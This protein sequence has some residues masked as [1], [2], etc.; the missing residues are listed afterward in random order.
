VTASESARSSRGFDLRQPALL[1]V[2]VLTL[3]YLSVL[4]HVTNVVGGSTTLLLVVAATVVL[5]TVLGRF[6]RVRSAI[7]LTALILVGGLAAYFFSVPASNRALFTVERVTSDTIAL[8]TG[9]SVLRLTKAGTWALAIAPGPVFLSWYLALRREYVWSVVVGGSALLF[10]VL[11]GDAGAATTLFGVV[12]AAAAIG[13]DTL[14]VRGGWASQLDTLAVVLAAMIV[15]SATLSV[16]PGGAAQPLLQDRGATTV[17]SSLVASN[18]QVN[19]LGSIR[20]SPKVRFEVRSDSAAYWQTAAYDRYTGSGWVRSGEDEAYS[21]RVD[22]PPGAS[23]TV[24]QNVE[25]KTRMTALP[26]AWKPVSVSGISEST[27]RITHQGNIVTTESVRTNESFRVRSELPRYTREQLRRSGSDYPSRISENYLQLPETTSDRVRGQA[28]E[29]AGNE[30]NAYDKAKAIEQYLESSKEYSLTVQKP[31]GDIAESFL[32]EMDAGY[33]TYYATSMVVMLRS[34]GIPARFVSGYTTGQQVADDKYVVRGLDS[35]AWVQVY[36]P[37]VGWVDFDPT[38]SGPRQTAEGAR[39]EEARQNQEEGVDTEETDPESATEN[40]SNTTETPTTPE[41]ETPTDNE[42]NQ[43]A[44][45]RSTVDPNRILDDEERL[46]QDGSSGTSTTGVTTTPDSSSGLPSLPSRETL[47]VG[48]ALMVGLAAGARRTGATERATRFVWMYYQ[49]ARED[50]TTDTERAFGRL[51]YCLERRYRARRPR[52]TP[53]SY[54]SALS[55]VG[56]D[57]RAKEVGRLYEQA[58]YGTGVS[59]A[60]ADRAIDLVDSLVREELPV[61]G[62]LRN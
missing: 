10:F 34:Q 59:R 12:G 21:G 16:V 4:Y 8:L 30:T 22:G 43:S 56:L 55:K 60:E 32:F 42:T 17:E 14:S 7:L 44:T 57:E 54:L 41:P 46:G 18:D 61:V 62:R 45:N 33:C 26:S 36:F 29:I 37:D 3:S 53:R 38:P 24:V 13:L 11:T 23:R 50:P 47:G 15:L 20:L 52:E 9:L 6:L 35:H 49:G 25:A 40:E 51:E 39:L 27:L 48:L 28:A 1:G 58:H 2:A 19:I 5:A 31:E